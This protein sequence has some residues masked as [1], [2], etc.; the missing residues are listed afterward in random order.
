MSNSP[1]TD[2]LRKDMEQLRK[3]LG[4]LSDS[5]KHSSNEYAQASLDMARERFN[6]LCR[7]AGRHTQ[8]L[9]G[10][11]EARPFTSILAA[12]GIGLLLGKIF[13]R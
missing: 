8:E 13:G 6:E 12:F 3:D 2:A 11:I 4:A 5:V 1:E 10:E 7:E 9:S